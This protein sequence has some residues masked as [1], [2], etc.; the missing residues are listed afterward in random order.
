MARSRMLFTPAVCGCY[1]EPH[2]RLDMASQ[3][4]L[5]LGYRHLVVHIGH[6]HGRFSMP[7]SSICRMDRCSSITTCR[8]VD[9]GCECIV[10]KNSETSLIVSISQLLFTYTLRAYHGTRHPAFESSPKYTPYFPSGPEDISP[11]SASSPLHRLKSTFKYSQSDVSVHMHNHSNATLPKYNSMSTLA[12]ETPCMGPSRAPSAPSVPPP[13]D[14]PPLGISPPTSRSS[15]GSSTQF[16]T[17]MPPQT[18]PVSAMTAPSSGPCMLRRM[19]RM[20]CT[21]VTSDAA[22]PS[23]TPSYRERSDGQT[24]PRDRAEIRSGRPGPGLRSAGVSQDLL[25]HASVPPHD[26]D[27]DDARQDTDT[28]GADDGVVYAYGYGAQGPTYPYLDMYTPQRPGGCAD[29]AASCADVDEHGVLHG[30]RRAGACPEGEAWEAGEASSGEEE[31][32]EAYVVMMGGFVRRM[33]TIASLGSR[34]G[35]GAGTG[36]HSTTGTGSAARRTARSKTPGSPFSSVRFADERSSCAS[37]SPAAPWS[38]PG[39]LTTST[40]ASV[41]S[42]S[43]AISITVPSSKRTSLS[44]T[45]L[46]F[47]SGGTDTGIAVSMG[48]CVNERGERVPWPDPN[49]H[50][51]HAG[52][53]SDRHYDTASQSSVPRRDDDDDDDR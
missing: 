8:D 26:D 36:T 30:H 22:P 29:A 27:D 1:D 52:T 42:A 19:H 2:P 11:V 31:E 20:S 32:E 38:R 4:V 25:P 35:E 40:T 3:S 46:S 53:L 7:S 12:L 49:G 33:A 6:E 45:Y 41:S 37:G 10:G 17:E 24:T 15:S 9:R 16:R 21:Q 18:P 23:D 14:N 43:A 47:S 13:K 34:E 39:S 28:D 5:R 51:H 44:T 50:V 48:M